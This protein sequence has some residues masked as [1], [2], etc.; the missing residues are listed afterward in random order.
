MKL[1]LSEEIKPLVDS[2]TGLDL[3]VNWVKESEVAESYLNRGF[4]NSYDFNQ[5]A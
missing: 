5:T 3:R 4:G 2:E 1:E